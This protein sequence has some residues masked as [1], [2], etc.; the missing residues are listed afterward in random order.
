MRFLVLA[1]RGPVI[2]LRRLDVLKETLV[3]VVATI[4]AARFEPV[5][6]PSRREAPQ[7]TP[8]ASVRWQL[9]QQGV[10]VLSMPATEPGTVDDDNNAVSVSQACHY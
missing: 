7:F 1:G 3:S 9:L 10:L 5:V 6:L 8:V 2:E 4:E